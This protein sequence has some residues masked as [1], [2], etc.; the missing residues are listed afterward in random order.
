LEMTGPKAGVV[1]SGADQAVAEVSARA[2][3]HS[4]S[5]AMRGAHPRLSRAANTCRQARTAW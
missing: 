3:G 1:A 5:S 4:L 2:T